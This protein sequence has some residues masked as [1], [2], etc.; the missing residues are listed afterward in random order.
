MYILLNMVLSSVNSNLCFTYFC[1]S[2]NEGFFCF[3]NKSLLLYLGSPFRKDNLESM[4]IVTEI[5]S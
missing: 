3:M 2:K 4:P 1:L 5:V